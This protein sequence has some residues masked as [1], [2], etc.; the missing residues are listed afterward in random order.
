MLNSSIQAH[1]QQIMVLSLTE[2]DGRFAFYSFQPENIQSV[3]AVPVRKMTKGSKFGVGEEWD[4]NL[5]ADLHLCPHFA[6][7]T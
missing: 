7:P 6:G 5:L 2:Q 3:I 4:N 1:V